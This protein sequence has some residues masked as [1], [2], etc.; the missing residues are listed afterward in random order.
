MNGGR[1]RRVTSPVLDSAGVDRR[2]SR[3]ENGVRV[4]SERVPSVR[5]ASIGIWVRQGA[6]HEPGSR[7]GVSHLLEH[8]VF[9]GTERR[10]AA[11]IALS[12]EARG[13]SL[14]AYTSREH[15]SV[16]ARVLD[17]DLPE[18]VDVLSD[19][20]RHPLLR[21]ADLE[22]EREVV[23]EEIAEVDDTPDDLVHELFGQELWG[24]HPY[25]HQILGTRETVGGMS[26]ADLRDVHE[27]RYV[28]SNLVVAAAGHIEHDEVVRLAE[29]HLG[30]LQPGVATP[31]VPTPEPSAPRQVNV[32][33]D[34][35]QAHLVLG[36]Q[37]VPHA[38]RMRL[39]IVLI[40]Q[41]LGGGMSSRLFQRIRE[42]L[43]LV[44]TV[45]SF[46]S[47]HQAGGQTGVYLGTRPE[48]LGRAHEALLEEY[49]RLARHGLG[50]EEF[51]QTRQQLKG[52]VMLSL[53]S[54]VSRL[55]HMAGVAL[56]H[57]EWLDLD[58]LLARIDAVTLDEVQQAA[59]TWFSPEIQSSLVLGPTSG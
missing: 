51:E 1:G 42:E 41:A 24:A 23:L 21:E 17:H 19:L 38:H 5:S 22:L 7:M 58:G 52:Q 6:A 45:Y 33:R 26:A 28:A 35:A 27:G 12:L 11:Q 15:T 4:L 47:F 36:A 3:L 29:A 20:I 10:S 32:G 43:G 37:A 13:G 39:P 59:A 54:T 56:N 46:H 44:Y 31:D 55:Y 40:S 9:K 50:A 34:T 25:A 8:M 48:W 30:D 14:D 49:E 57:E 53:E 18:A 16:Q 2:E